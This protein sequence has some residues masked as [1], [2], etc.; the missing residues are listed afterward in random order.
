[1]SFE[2]ITPTDPRWLSTLST[3]N[4][5]IFYTP[6]YCGL[7]REHGSSPAMLL[8]QDD[9]GAA[10]DV[11]SVKE[12]ASLPFYE[13]VAGEFTHS[14]IDLA[15]P[16]Y[17]GPIVVSDDTDRHELLR[18]YRNAV[19]RFCADNNVVTEFVRFHPLYEGSEALSSIENLIPVSDILYVD[20]REG[21]EAARK[22]YR[23]GHKWAAQKAAR[24]GASWSIVEPNDEHLPTFLRLYEWTQRRNETRNMYVQEEPFF[25]SLFKALKGRALLAESYAHGDVVSSSIFLDDRTCLWYQY[26]GSA[27]DLLGTN[28]H[29]YLMDRMVAWAASKGISYLVLGGG[30]DPHDPADGIAK[31]KRGFSHLMGKVHQLKKVHHP[32]TLETLQLA[33]DRYNRSL[34]REVQGNWFPSY[35]LD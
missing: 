16:I 20:L 32:A 26:S 7:H 24:D 11:T 18:R 10:F 5:G 28:A 15:N 31:F 34:G 17:N 9:L 21:Y 8:Y 13:S 22:Q 35:W 19:D 33:K 25:R 14:P 2:V 30:G 12:V 23:K 29:T 6:E 1:M 27:L 4:A 3:S